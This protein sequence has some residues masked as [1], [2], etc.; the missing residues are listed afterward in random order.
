MTYERKN[1]EPELNHV[2]LL[3]IQRKDMVIVEPVKSDKLEAL[4][5]KALSHKFE[6]EKQVDQA[7]HDLNAKYNLSGIFN[8]AEKIEK[9]KT[10]TIEGK[11]FH[12]FQVN[13][14]RGKLQ[15]DGKCRFVKIKDLITQIIVNIKGEGDCVVTP[16]LKM[17]LN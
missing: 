15:M 6:D 16:S 1:P 4:V 3:L 2:C 10:F 5:V 9:L 12:V 14:N 8:P 13:Q 11:T 17:A 7:L